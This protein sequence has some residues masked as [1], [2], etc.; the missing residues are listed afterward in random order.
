MPYN[1]WVQFRRQRNSVGL[2]VAQAVLL[3][4]YQTRPLIHSRWNN[5]GRYSPANVPLIEALPAWAQNNGGVVTLEMNGLPPELLDGIRNY[6]GLLESIIS[7]QPRI[8]R[9]TAGGAVI[10][11]PTTDRLYYAASRGLPALQ[12]HATL[13]PRI[14]LLPLVQ[15][16]GG[17]LVHTLVPMRHAQTCAEFQALNQALMDG[18]DEGDLELWCFKAATMEPVPRCPNCQITVPQNALAKIWTS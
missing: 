12:I 8:I 5:H 2:P 3:H 7:H 15:G 9:G 16:P 11:N 18:A 1:S 4:E 6:G 14:Q 10:Y 13:A 17:I